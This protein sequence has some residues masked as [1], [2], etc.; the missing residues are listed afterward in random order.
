MKLFKLPGAQM[1][2]FSLIFVLN[3]LENPRLIVLHAF[4]GKM[5]LN[6]S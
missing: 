5:C 6:I 4:Q 1:V 2:C 3:D